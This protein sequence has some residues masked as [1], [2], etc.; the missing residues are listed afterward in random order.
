MPCPR[1]VAL[2]AADIPAPSPY[3]IDHYDVTALTPGQQS[4]WACVICERPGGD[5]GLIPVGYAARAGEPAGQVFACA[6]CCGVNVTAADFTPERTFPVR[7][8]RGQQ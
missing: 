7:P 4:G 2:D 5:E 3:S 8:R 6:D 1:L